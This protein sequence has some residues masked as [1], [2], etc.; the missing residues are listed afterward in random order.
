MRDDPTDRETA[1][2]FP[3]LAAFFGAY[4]DPVW[5]SRYAS[6]QEAALDF[7][8]HQDTP[9][10]Q[11]VLRELTALNH[12]DAADAQLEVL[13][14]KH[15]GC[16]ADFAAAGGAGNWVRWLLIRVRNHLGDELTS[17]AFARPLDLPLH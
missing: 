15:L 12:L 11:A 1:A 16:H 13:L 10:V 9:G 7:M 6:W 4:F 8:F 3:A 5:T 2:G 17:L 14:R